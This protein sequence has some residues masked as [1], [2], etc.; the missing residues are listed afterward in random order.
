MAHEPERWP[1]R[2]DLDALVENSD[3]LFIYAATIVRYMEGRGSPQ[4][5]LRK[6]L[7]RHVGADLLYDHIISEANECPNFNRVIGTL[8]YLREPIP[9]L[10]LAQLLQL[11]VSEIRSAL[12]A[13]HSVLIIP[14]SND[15]SIRPYHASLRDY[16]TD[17]ER[18]DNA[19][20]D[21]AQFHASITVACLRATSNNPSKYA[22][23]EWYYHASCL[24]ASANGLEGRHHCLRVKDELDQLSRG[25]IRDW[26]VE[27]LRWKGMH[28]ITP[29][30][31]STKVSGTHCYPEICFMSYTGNAI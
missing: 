18:S 20:C 25:R 31:P 5:N 10:D 13:C 12:E 9:I 26:M 27:S 30:L 14:N 1:S 2:A 29:K 7:T 17:R 16:L 11:D 28:H 24:I 21:P 3:G 6:V 22:W 19:F 8:V 4:A 23:L 15:D